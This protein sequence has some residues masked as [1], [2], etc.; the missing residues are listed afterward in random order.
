MIASLPM[1]DF[2]TTVAANDRLWAAIR[3]GLRA[4]GNAAPEA[5]SR[6]ADDLFAHWLAPDLVLS[7]TCGLPYR[8]RLHGH[9]TLIGTPDFAVEGCPP[10]H[11][12][13]LFIA[14]AA[15]PRAALADFDGAAFAYNDAGSQSGWAAPQAHAAGLGLHLRPAL[16]TGGHRLSAQAVA[17]GKAD[18]A[19]IDAVT[20]RLLTRD[21]PA[22]CAALRVVGMTAPS[23]GLPYVSARGADTALIFDIIATAIAGLAPGDRETLGLRGLVAIPAAEYLSVPTPPA[24]EAIVAQD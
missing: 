8:A 19:A 13:S 18:L 14:R 10:G 6:G 22:L 2:G 24:P 21:D 15:D 23:P 4:A 5:L 11:Y 17:A 16:R 12:R 7:Q 3:D 1:Y 20:W 9:V